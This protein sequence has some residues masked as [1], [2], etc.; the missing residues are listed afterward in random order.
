MKF[1]L[2]V[3]SFAGLIFV[4]LALVWVSFSSAPVNTTIAK[5][6][7]GKLVP[8]PESAVAAR[9]AKA[10]PEGLPIT[11]LRAELRNATRRDDNNI[12]VAFVLINTTIVPIRLVQRWNSWGENQ[13]SFHATDSKGVEYAL[14]PRAI[15]HTKNIFRTFTIEPF[16]EYVMPCHLVVITGPPFYPPNTFDYFETY[17][18][19][20]QSW[21]FPI[22]ITGTFSGQLYEKS[23]YGDDEGTNWAGSIKTNS[24][25]VG[26]MDDINSKKVATEK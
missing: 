10:P 24:I 23:G 17:V 2:K 20:T 1:R 9:T 19:P 26:L 6:V 5:A 25:T 14:N 4:G 22:V 7:S 16:G 3:V 13:W 21:T 18:S 15:R 11:V 12:D 8:A